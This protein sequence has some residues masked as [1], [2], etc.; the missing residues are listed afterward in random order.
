MIGPGADSFASKLHYPAEAKATGREGA[1]QFY[2]EVNSDGRARH[3]RVIGEDAKGPFRAVVQE[4]L[5]KG[6]FLAARS[7]GHVTKV[8]VGGTV[9]FLT[10]KGQPTIV[11]SLAA[12]E[13]EKAAGVGNYIQPQMLMSYADLERKCMIWWRSMVTRPSANPAAEILFDVDANGHATGVKV[14]GESRGSALGAVLLKACDGA[15]FIPAQANGKNVSGQF[16]LPID[17]RMMTDPDAEVEGHLRAPE[18]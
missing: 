3:A 10:A 16:N 7:D 6:R 14:V 17:F 4:A 13:K 1:V 9:L 8:L 11:V 18:R 5:L 2:C 15:H 12:A